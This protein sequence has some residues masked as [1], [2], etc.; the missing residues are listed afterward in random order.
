MPFPQIAKNNLVIA[1]SM[2]SFF[3]N[4]QGQYWPL[5]DQINGLAEIN[6]FIT[7]QRHHPYQKTNS[8]GKNPAK[9]A[10]LGYLSLES[11]IDLY[12]IYGN[13]LPYQVNMNLAYLDENVQR[14]IHKYFIDNILRENLYYKNIFSSSFIHKTVKELV[15][16]KILGYST[17]LPEQTDDEW[18]IFVA[19]I[20]TGIDYL[21]KQFKTI[22]RDY[23]DK[24]DSFRKGHLRFVQNYFDRCLFIADLE[25]W[26]TQIPSSHFS[27]PIENDKV[28]AFCQ[29][30]LEL[31]Q[32]YNEIDLKSFSSLF[33][34]LQNS[35]ITPEQYKS[36]CEVLIR[37]RPK[38][39]AYRFSQDKLSQEQ[40]LAQWMELWPKPPLPTLV[41]ISLKSEAELTWKK[42]RE[43]SRK[44]QEE[45]QSSENLRHKPSI[46]KLNNM[47]D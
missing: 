46:A 38:Y 35:K 39:D 3:T 40:Q 10:L 2:G 8:Q 32:P 22:L 6:K 44:K 47:V 21:C 45:Q 18:Q 13:K 37:L 12:M 24:F 9:T 7:W 20:N 41:S 42:S 15:Q 27:S 14:F 17:P 16:E 5:D 26:L 23:Y 11:S 19:E 31:E 43:K 25:K 1:L 30:L 4:D 36:I 28:Q 33:H 29:K 34:N